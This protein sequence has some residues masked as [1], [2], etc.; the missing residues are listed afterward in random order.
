MAVFDLL[1]G[2]GFGLMEMTS[3]IQN[4]P[5]L[6]TYLGDKMIFTPKPVR[7]EMVAIEENQGTLTI[8]QTSPRG[9]P[10][11]DR[12]MEK[13]K[14]RYFPTNRI[15]KK[16]TILASS[17]AFIRAFGSETEFKQLAGEVISAQTGLARDIALTK[18]RMRLGAIKGIVLDA[19]GS[20]IRNWYTEFGV[21]APSTIAFAIPT[22]TGSDT[23]TGAVYT[24][25]QAVITA[26]MD[27]AKEM[28]LPGTEVEAL[29]GATFFDKLVAT[30]ET[31]ANYRAQLA[32][33]AAYGNITQKSTGAYATFDYGGIRFVKY[34]GSSDGTVAVAATEARFYPVGAHPD[35]FQEAMSPGESFAQ[36]GQL[37]QD[38]YSMLEVDPSGLDEWVRV[39]AR[40]YP[41][42][43][44]S[45]P[46]VLQVGSA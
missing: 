20:T 32:A 27:A 41:L 37:G 24:N 35:L 44:C 3:S 12:D 21:S 2:D 29:C 40:A 1:K 18:E 7:T 4:T 23:G 33:Q 31:R 45:R 6:P 30:N 42:M 36:Q 11:D 13:R 10:V 22:G 28:W 19:D 17:I 16:A 39:H 14:L 5:H 15:A 43:I 46:L 8:I 34:R 9:A 26:M 38:V 25:C